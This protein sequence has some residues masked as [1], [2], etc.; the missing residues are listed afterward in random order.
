MSTIRPVLTLAGIGVRIVIFS[1]WESIVNAFLLNSA[2]A[3]SRL[4]NTTKPLSFNVLIS[5]VEVVNKFSFS[6]FNSSKSFISAVL[7]FAHS[8]KA[9]PSELFK[10]NVI[11]FEYSRNIDTD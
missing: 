2:Y 1:A 8:C 7:V 5:R 11:A 9:P 10:W 6:S 4:V 3:R